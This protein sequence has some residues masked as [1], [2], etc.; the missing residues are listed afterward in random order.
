M[1]NAAIFE[2]LKFS[3]NWNNKLYGNYFTT[4]RINSDKYKIGRKFNVF[5]S[6][7]EIVPFKV[8]CVQK[9]VFLF[10]DIP[11]LLMNLDTGLERAAAIEVF[12]SFYGDKFDIYQY[13]VCV[14]KRL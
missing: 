12:K 13:C 11:Q 8:V 3:K 2:N 6:N 10:N 1:E 4:I 9:L 7:S 5:V 14:F